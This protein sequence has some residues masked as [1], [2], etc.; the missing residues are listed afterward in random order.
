MRVIMILIP[1]QNE[2]QAALLF[3]C[4]LNSLNL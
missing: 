1:I 2:E 3:I 4:I